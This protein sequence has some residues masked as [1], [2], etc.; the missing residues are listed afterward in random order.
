MP[1]PLSLVAR[2]STWRRPSSE[3]STPIAPE[4]RFSS[5]SGVAPWRTRYTRV[6]ISAWFRGSR[7]SDHVSGR[8]LAAPVL[9][10]DLDGRVL[11]PE[12]IVEL[13]CDPPQQGVVVAGIRLDEVRG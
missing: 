9:P 4:N 1:S 2:R 7:A 3:R 12:A 5:V 11:D 8:L 6:A 10:F 13:A